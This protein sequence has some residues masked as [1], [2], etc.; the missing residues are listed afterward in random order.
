MCFSD[1]GHLMV[2]VDQEPFK[3]AERTVG[4][5]PIFG[6]G[7]EVLTTKSLA[8]GQLAVFI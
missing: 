4:A 7:L 1:S 6:P 8:A 5:A 3:M 2:C